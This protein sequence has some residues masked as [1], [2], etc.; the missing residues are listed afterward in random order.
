M[1]DIENGVELNESPVET[2]KV[3]LI[4]FLILKKWWKFV[5]GIAQQAKDEEI[6]DL[7]EN[8]S[9]GTVSDH[10]IIR[11]DKDKTNFGFITFSSSEDVD[12]VLNRRKE[13][14]FNGKNLDV[15][16]A[17]PKNSNSPGAHER[18]KKLFIANLP[19]TNCTEEDLKEYFEARH[20]LMYGTIESVQ[21]KKKK[22][23]KV[24]N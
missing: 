10:V 17:V 1:A 19:K 16:R 24:I 5:G 14:L 8:V 12:V 2:K 11:K 20:D 23:T 21:L 7:F 9:G 15:N 13:L 4:Q 22:M 3:A 6:Q 18:T